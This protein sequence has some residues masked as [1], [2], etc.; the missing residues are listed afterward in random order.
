MFVINIYYRLKLSRMRIFTYALLLFIT[1]SCSTHSDTANELNAE[2]LNTK[3]QTLALHDSLMQKLPELRKVTSEVKQTLNDSTV[4]IKGIMYYTLLDDLTAADS[5]MWGWM[6]HFDI[7]YQGVNDSATLVYFRKKQQNL[8][9]VDSM[10]TTSL[11]R[12]KIRLSD[13]RAQ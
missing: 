1:V 6:H 7:A 4:L 8:L 5:A 11:K 3:N 9:V 13:G 12:A 10:I 2:I